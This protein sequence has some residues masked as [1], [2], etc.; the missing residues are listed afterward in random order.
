MSDA[1]NPDFRECPDDMNTITAVMI[2]KEEVDALQALVV[3]EA[4]AVVALLVAAWW[5][6]RQ[7]R[8]IMRVLHVRVL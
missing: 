6:I 5:M 1:L 2:T 3:A 8:R 7:Q 4:A